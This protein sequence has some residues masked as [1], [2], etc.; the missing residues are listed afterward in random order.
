MLDDGIFCLGRPTPL[1]TE[2]ETTNMATRNDPAPHALAMAREIVEL[3]GYMAAREQ[4]DA[5]KAEA[6]QRATIMAKRP[7]LS[8]AQA[9]VLAYV[10]LADLPKHLEALPRVRTAG[11]SHERT[12]TVNPTLGRLTADERVMLASVHRNDAPG[13]D[14]VRATKRGS[15]LEM[16]MHIPTPTQAAARIKE[17]E[18][19]LAAHRAQMAVLR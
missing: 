15:V 10:P 3:K 7:D 9:A 1:F 11:R 18:G 8:A 19:E 5:K 2:T 12:Q 14:V 4:A 6:D 13:G 16:P 17:L